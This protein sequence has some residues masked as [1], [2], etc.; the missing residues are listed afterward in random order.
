MN[1]E[2]KSKKHIIVYSTNTCPYCVMVK[3]YLKQKGF[4]F[5]DKNVSMD[6]LAGIEMVRKS[7]QQGVPVVDIDG[8][9]IVGFNK[10]VIDSVLGL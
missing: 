1:N 9:I 6:M 7:G 2:S 3:Q 4:S 5:E 10:P 8:K